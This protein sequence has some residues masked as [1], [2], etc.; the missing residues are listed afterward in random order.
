M[1][2]QVGDLTFDA[3]G[4]AQRGLLVRHLVMPNGLAGTGEI[5]A[6]LTRHVSRNTHLNVMGQYHPDG[7]VCHPDRA[8]PYADLDRLLTRDELRGARQAAARAGLERSQE[9]RDWA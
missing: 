2:R 1:H 5:A 9:P 3:D 7:A 4:L 8:G 6:W